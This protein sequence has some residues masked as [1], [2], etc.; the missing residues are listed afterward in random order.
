MA[1]Q[2]YPI[3]DRATQE[4]T[5]SKAFATVAANIREP[6]WTVQSNVFL[7]WKVKFISIF[8]FLDL[9]EDQDDSIMWENIA[10]MVENSRLKHRITIIIIDSFRLNVCR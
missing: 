10:P 4:A 6:S 2:Q 9:P 1:V 7:L 5:A 3:C 8:C